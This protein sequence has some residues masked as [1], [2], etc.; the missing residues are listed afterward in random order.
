M[1]T[2]KSLLITALAGV[3][4]TIMVGCSKSYNA[5]TTTTPPPPPAQSGIVLNTSATLGSYLTDKQ[6]HALYSFANDA[7]GHDSCTGACALLW[8]AFNIDQLTADKL[9]SGLDLSDFG[10]VTTPGGGNQLTYKGWPLYTYAPPSNGAN[11][12]EAA[13]LTSGDGF[14]NLWFVAKPDYTI[15]LANAQLVGLDGKNYTSTYTEGIG[16]TLYFTTANGITLY[17]FTKD[18]ANHN[19]FTAADF[20]NNNVFPI[21]DTSKI[22]VPSTLSK[23]DFETIQVA[24]RTQ[25][26][27]KG[28]PLYN[29]GQDGTTRGSNKAV[30]VPHPGVWPVAVEGV[31]KAPA[32]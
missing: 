28:W 22:V 11:T 8:P 23:T 1:E 20:S 21:Y 14:A 25:L 10:S 18:S 3:A 12:P 2:R 9:G 15:M 27:Y 24:G 16:K 19:K 29:F 17:T 26:T 7:D 5:P 31:A 4:V 32:P 6:N 13:G 30:S